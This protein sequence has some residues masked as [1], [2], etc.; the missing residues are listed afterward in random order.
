MKGKKKKGN[1]EKHRG[2]PHGNRPY[3]N[4]TKNQDT[5]SGKKA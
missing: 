1:V 3:Q 4:T 2:N 5:E